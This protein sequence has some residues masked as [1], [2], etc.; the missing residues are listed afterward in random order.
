MNDNGNYYHFLVGVL[1]SEYDNERSFVT[2][3]GYTEVLPGRITTDR[4]VSSEGTSYFDMLNNAMKL[5]SALDFNSQGDGKL[6]LK[7]TLV[8]SQ[9]GTKKAISVATVVS[10]TAQQRISTA[11]K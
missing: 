9:S 7:G 6:R 2:L 1:N 11:M 10:I 3:Y 5:G 4:I 8:Q